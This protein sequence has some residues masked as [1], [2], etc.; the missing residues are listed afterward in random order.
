[1]L[2]ISL[3]IRTS[4]K[5]EESV[6]QSA[7]KEISDGISREEGRVV[8]SDGKAASLGKQKLSKKS[9]KVVYEIRLGSPILY[10]NDHTG[11][12]SA[13]RSAAVRQNR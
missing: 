12:Y 5:L 6:I 2:E 11:S 13:E 3:D 10:L 4:Q 1:M 9:E 7:D 8:A